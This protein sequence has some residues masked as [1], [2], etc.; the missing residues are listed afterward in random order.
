MGNLRA[1][2]A[3]MLGM[4]CRALAVPVTRAASS[5]RRR[6][7]ALEFWIEDHA[8]PIVGCAWLVLTGAIVTLLLWKT[9]KVISLAAA[10]GP[11][12]GLIIA[13][14]GSLLAVARALKTRRD[15]RAGGQ[16]IGND[17]PSA[18][19]AAL[20]EAGPPPGQPSSATPAEVEG[21]GSAASG[22]DPGD[23]AD[24][25]PAGEST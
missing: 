22:E 3:R 18:A 10:F 14:T 16:Q 13:I 2:A 25:D 24:G 19:D 4:R 6:F 15:Q 5:I 8:E 23:P 11:V 21:V 20:D 9:A 17:T 12:I 7:R 1:R